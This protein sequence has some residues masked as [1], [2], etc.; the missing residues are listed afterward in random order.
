[1]VVVL[2]LLSGCDGSDADGAP[3]PTTVEAGRQYLEIIVEAAGELEPLRTVEV[4][5][6]ASGEVIQVLVDT[7]DE[8]QTGTLLAL[9]D[10]RDVQNDFNQAEA[11]YEVASE[12][13]TIAGAQLR[14]SESLLEAGV[15]TEQEHE[16]RDLEFANSRAA[17]VRAETNLELARLRLADVTIGSPMDGTV[18]QKNVEEGQV[19]SSPS[20]N[21]S[22]GTVL[23]TIADLQVMQVRT[24]VSEVDVGR[25]MA[26]MPATVSV[27]AF[28]DRIFS[29]VV[30]KI[31]PQAVIEQS[32]VNFPVIVRLDNSERILKPG[33]SANVS[34][35]LAERPDAI[36]LPNNTIIA[37]E[38]IVAAAAVLG[39][40][41][42]RL[43][44]DPSV[45][46]ELRRQLAGRGGRGRPGPEVSDGEEETIGAGEIVGAG[47]TVVAGGRGPDNLQ[48]LR[49]RVQ[50]GDLS[51]EEVQ[52]L[53]QARGERPASERG[54]RS[55]GGT[56][57]GSRSGVV[58]VESP[59]G[60]L[61]PRAVL[62][63]IT[64]WSNS[65]ILAGLNEGERVA[66]IA[67]AGLSEEMNQG[68]RFRG[69]RLGI[70]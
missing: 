44:M 26:G 70:F 8:V 58:F 61:L 25:V 60:A 49:E 42:D 36:T 24:L 43:E 45:F 16:G 54:P 22:G 10:P 23:L 41:E 27:D 3:A 31:E 6:K 12:R 63:G 55:R 37:F 66:L 35:L 13:L 14:R 2:L 34:V 50:R 46:Q 59:D 64:D 62:I 47:E 52:A 19:I 33:M 30:E 39:V 67:V 5:S 38:Q 68:F 48:G 20:G 9:I 40:P 65:E 29:G 7:G 11:D 21:V 4:M 51:R 15:I 57:S 18:L 53:I 56:A 28:Q 69:G 32:V 17:L 1:V